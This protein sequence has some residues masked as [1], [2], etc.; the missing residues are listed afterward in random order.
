[1]HRTISSKASRQLKKS[2]IGSRTSSEI[3]DA[4]VVAEESNP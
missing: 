1:M 4:E 3:S 2:E